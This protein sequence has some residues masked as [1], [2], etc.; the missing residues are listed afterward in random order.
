VHFISWVVEEETTQSTP[1]TETETTASSEAKL[2]PV[3]VISCPSSRPVL[4]ETL[5]TDGWMTC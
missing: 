3:M 1:S 5:K 2:F 4:G